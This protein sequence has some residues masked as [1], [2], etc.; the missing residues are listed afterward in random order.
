[1]APFFI[2]HYLFQGRKNKA[3]GQLSKGMGE[4]LIAFTII[5]DRFQAQHVIRRGLAA[6]INFQAFCR[7]KP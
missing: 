3:Y 6:K 2:S 4:E 1:M 7:H 5:G